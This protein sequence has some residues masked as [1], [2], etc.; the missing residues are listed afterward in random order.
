MTIFDQA[1]SWTRSIL[2]QNGRPGPFFPTDPEAE[3]F[4]LKTVDLNR[5]PSENSE[6]FSEFSENFQKILKIIFR[7]FQKIFWKLIQKNFLKN[8]SEKFWKIF[9]KLWKIFRD[10]AKQKSVMFA[11]SA[12]INMSGKAWHDAFLKET[13]AL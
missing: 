8:F 4:W 7:K 9:Q 2:N 3:Q 6:K 11:R 10:F 1:G 13:A 5:W 12:N